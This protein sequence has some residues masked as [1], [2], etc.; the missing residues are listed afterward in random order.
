MHI[1]MRSRLW[2]LH[3][4]LQMSVPSPISWRFVR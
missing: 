2:T 3:G 1:S 4:S